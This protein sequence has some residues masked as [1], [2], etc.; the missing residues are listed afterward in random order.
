MANLLDAIQRTPPVAWP[1]LPRLL[2]AGP[3]LFFSIVHFIN[4]QHFR[5]VLIAGDMPLPEV[6]VIAAT[7]AELLGGLLLLAGFLARFGGLL[8]V[9]TMLPAILT[10]V[11]LAGRP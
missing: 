1:L 4:P 7:S 5:D 9:A 11:R 3:L 2:A 8:G 6:N 10:T